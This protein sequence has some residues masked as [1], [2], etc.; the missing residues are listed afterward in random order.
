[1]VRG[2][3]ALALLGFALPSAMAVAPL[4][5][6]QFAAADATIGFADVN[7]I[8]AQHYAKDGVVF[9]G[10]RTLRSHWALSAAKL[11]GN[12]P[13]GGW[14]DKKMSFSFVKPGTFIPA[15]VTRVGLYAAGESATVELSFFGVS[16]QKLGVQTVKNG[17]G[18]DAKRWRG[19]E[20]KAGIARV[21]V[22]S[23][24][25]GIDS[26]RFDTPVSSEPAGAETV[27]I[28]A[29]AFADSDAT[30]SFD[31]I[32]GPK[33]YTAVAAHY[34]A[35]GVTFSG[36]AYSLP[37]PWALSP[38]NLV[39]SAAGKLGV[40][41]LT[42]AFNRG[43]KKAYVSRVGFYVTGL[44]ER[45]L[46]TLRDVEDDVIG[47]Y[48]LECGGGLDR[49]R[50]YGFT[51]VGIHSVS[52][53]GQNMLAGGFG[54]DNLRFDAP[55][56]EHAIALAPAGASAFASD[57]RVLFSARDLS[58]GA[59]LGKRFDREGVVFTDARAID[60]PAGSGRAI[61]AAGFRGGAKAAWGS[62]P[63]T[64]TFVLPG[65][66]VPATATRAGVRVAGPTGQS[67]LLTLFDQSGTIITT[68]NLKNLSPKGTFIGFS[69]KQGIASVRVSGEAYAVDDVRFGG[70]EGFKNGEA[71]MV[72]ESAFASHFG[73]VG[74][75][76]LV[77]VGVPV[78]GT[79]RA[80][81][82]VFD[83]SVTTMA[84]KWA[85]AKLMA[86]SGASVGEWGDKQMSFSFVLPG[87]A[88]PA[89]VSDVGFYVAGHSAT[90]NVQLLDRF[91][92]T[93]GA[94]DVA[95]GASKDGRRWFGFHA[96]GIATV[97]INSRSYAIDSV[98]FDPPNGEPSDCVLGSW[99]AFGACSHTCG[100]GY[101]T[102]SRPVVHAPKFGGKMCAA[103]TNTKKCNAQ[104]CPIDCVLG[105]F[106]AWST[107]SKSCGSGSQ[108]R[109]R[110]VRRAAAF[111]GYACAKL[112]EQ[113]ACNAEDCP[114]DC[115]MGKW[116]AWTK[117]AV[118]CGGAK[119]H[120]Y[121]S[122]DQVSVG[123]KMCPHRTET[124][125]CN[126]HACPI[127]CVLG[128]WSAW[129]K[130][131]ATCG[132]GFR[133]RTRPFT[134]K[135]ANGGKDCLHQHAFQHKTCRAKP[136]PIDCRPT[137]WGEWTPCPV[138]C[139]GS[140]HTRHRS[141]A[142]AG[143]LGGKAC[144]VLKASRPC[145]AHKCPVDCK[146][147]TFSDWSPCDKSCGTGKST[148]A[149]KVAQAR[150]GGVS[151]AHTREQRPCNEHAC[152]VD[153]V[154]H[155]FVPWSTCTRSCGADGKQTRVRPVTEPAMGGEQCP[156]LASRT[157]DRTCNQHKCPQ[158]CKLAQWRSWSVCTK[159][160][161]TG[162][163]K[164]SRAILV[165]PHAGGMACIHTTETRSCNQHK[166]P[167]DCVVTP[168]TAWSPCSRS[169][170]SGSQGRGRS[171]PRLTAYGGVECPAQ[172]SQTRTCNAHPCPVDCVV[173]SNFDHWST[174]TMSCGSGSQRRSRPITTLNS[175]GGKACAHQ[176][177]TRF[178]NTH[179]C[180]IDCV[181]SK[182]GGWGACNKGCGTGKQFRT[183]TV[184]VPTAFGGVECPA[185][186]LFREGQSC[187][188]DPCPI[189]CK[190]APWQEF[191]A[192]S[193]TC[194]TGV[195]QRKRSVMEPPAHGGTYCPQ[196][197]QQRTCMTQACPSDCALES[198][199]SW[200][201]CSL[202]CGGGVHTRTREVI[203][204]NTFG[205]KACAD[206][207]Q[208]RSCNNFACPVDCAMS[209]FSPWTVCSRTCGGGVTV[210][211]RVIKVPVRSGGRLCP[212]LQQ[213]NTCNAQPCP[214]DCEVS[215]WSVWSECTVSCGAAGKKR[216]TRFAKTNTKG[217]K[218]C[219]ALTE[220]TPCDKGPC[221]M[222]CEVTS[223]APWSTCTKSCGTGTQTR[224]R[225]IA[226]KPSGPGVQCPA[227]ED[228]R[229]CNASECPVD[230][231]KQSFGDIAL[232]SKCSTS[233][234]Q[235]T[236]TR[237]N[238]IFRPATYGG[239]SCGSLVETR[240]CFHARCPTDC[241]VAPWSAWGGCSASCGDGLHARYRKV[242][243][244]P[245]T[246]GKKC[247]A[248]RQERECND[249]PCPVH[250][251]VT[252]WGLFAPCTRSCGSTG[253]KVRRR[254]VIRHALHG[255]FVC[256]SLSETQQC[257][258][259][260]CPADCIVTEW[261]SWSG[262]SAT[263]GAGLLSRS[264]KVWESATNG[265]QDC[266]RILDQK[267][268][269][270]GP[271]PIDCAVSS[272][273]SF[274]SCSHSCAGGKKV[275]MRWI[276]KQAHHSGTVCPELKEERDCNEHHCP[277]DCVMDDWKVWSECST[278]C[279]P[280][281][282]TRTRDVSTPANLGGKA[283]SP[284]RSQTGSCFSGPCPQACE[285]SKW[286]A[287]GECT[288]PCGI[289]FRVRTR[290]VLQMGIH[291]ECPWLSATERCNTHSCIPPTPVMDHPIYQWG[292]SAWVPKPTPA[293][294]S[295]PKPAHCLVGHWGTFSKCTAT[296][297][298]GVTRRVRVNVDPVVG[299]QPCP[300]ANEVQTCNTM[301]CGHEK[302]ACKWGVGASET[303]VKNGWQGNGWGENK[304]A[305]CRCYNGEMRCGH[306][307]KSCSSLSKLQRC[308]AK[309][310]CTFEFNYKAGHNVMVTHAKPGETVGSQ[311][312][313][314]FN[315]QTRACECRC[316]GAT[317]TLI[318]DG[319][320]AV[321][322]EARKK[323]TLR[324]QPAPLIVDQKAFH[325]V[326][327]LAPSFLLTAS[328]L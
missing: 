138:S 106:S 152:P 135:G 19:F 179:A 173:R 283:C 146:H 24:S 302:F 133:K 201:E 34:A 115:K 222:N 250:C 5:S 169:C 47:Q 118:S 145:N 247:P 76:S 327:V 194:G 246:H 12:G 68:H 319:A 277:I 211:T 63:M 56:T 290:S 67:V 149:R 230:C 244:R 109:R 234:G 186:H 92:K 325:E 58:H 286:G 240:S 102:R 52:V 192:C 292:G 82:I 314:G 35:R 296:C 185:A 88:T 155:E 53:A 100:T 153:C 72:Q 182:W 310:T 315:F 209:N 114:T 206:S 289:G 205:G 183:R 110:S 129:A 130:C 306:R 280:G 284:I 170:G 263:C 3:F 59:V 165:P 10:A 326:P 294:T 48:K 291:H 210:R 61:M 94:F 197:L 266:P 20:D 213:T 271:C 221:G 300:H 29:G 236:Q 16:G 137:K 44:A 17:I 166:C 239:K 161:G 69:A 46:V 190:V 116:S 40:K 204:P 156:S 57:T 65:S 168:W 4:D 299:G 136:C 104:A 15:V 202:T 219:P 6:A 134:T 264:R 50:Y 143:A 39:S 140:E 1:M 73:T 151:C 305:P 281:T 90:V 311:H 188:T 80:R 163:Q 49:D 257:S 120:R 297:G 184:D 43:D 229:G 189:H 89:T 97:R 223:W 318:W 162:A 9:H 237:M 175:F 243:T 272:W 242:L 262:C 23:S 75:N 207:E 195:Q 125:A 253:T 11:A 51:A 18:A 127:N 28:S 77:D 258:R 103:S 22:L 105:Q 178:C 224:S 13:A 285:V 268:C 303:Y 84:S 324:D 148:R 288:K 160:C 187:N 128:K 287:W 131:S 265:G 111:G 107:C 172:L 252:S 83:A 321:A 279:G 269:T 158:D 199:G 208:S 254:E 216:R 282:K 36:A 293:P 62:A 273:A 144:P 225:S 124:R 45:V 317:K 139:G 95:N 70:L 241:A 154:V 226:G 126:G 79:Y 71:T 181:L 167:V 157:Q 31:K 295:P 147:G 98:K 14:G 274:S 96:A 267:P 113:Q 93:L 54:L 32:G 66:L 270:F 217:G 214:I 256:P 261:G 60:A 25:Y 7:G 26:V 193:R 74:F 276:T 64:T 320:E 164:R 323:V 55:R 38:A 235:G 99:T 30:I 191:T 307:K 248:V 228:T 121:R 312:H 255:G 91:G 21:E 180:P 117:C 220:F 249:G 108:K 231:V 198:W 150:H 176:A 33:T 142:I 328:N 218:A 200:G 227:L 78:A 259:K 232:W 123:G 141:I 86:R 203:T 112:Q 85:R 322:A 308:S 309:T 174:C 132:K 41:P 233:C 177:E 196:T 42:F 37:H 8:V 27:M 2:V 313:C 101:Q 238:K 260:S 298:G 301:S 245:D 171:T 159:S 87:S 119:Q 212:A 81:G 251:V 278:S 122:A 304:C 316:W 215:A 275:R